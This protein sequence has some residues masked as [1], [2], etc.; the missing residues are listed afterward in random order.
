MLNVLIH[1]LLKVLDLVLFLGVKLHFI[2]LFYTV[3]KILE[4]SASIDSPIPVCR[5]PLHCLICE[6]LVVF[7]LFLIEDRILSGSLGCH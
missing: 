5:K 7:C 6:G 4:S 2:L 3:A 1:C